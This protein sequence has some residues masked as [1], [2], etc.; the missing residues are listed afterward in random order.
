MAN[1]TIDITEGTGTSLDAEELTVSSTTVKRERMQ[2][3][4]TTAAAIQAVTNA[5]PSATEY[6]SAVRLVGQVAHDAADIGSPVKIGG[7]AVY[8]ETTSPAA[9]DRVDAWFNTNGAMFVH[10]YPWLGSRMRVVSDGT[11]RGVSRTNVALTSVTTV[12]SLLGA[13]GSGLYNYVIGMMLTSSA[14]S[15]TVL[16][17]ETVTGT[18][19]RWKMHTV[20]YQPIVVF[21]P[22][23]LYLFASLS[24]ELLNIKS[25]ASTDIN[26]VIFS[27]ASDQAV[28]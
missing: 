8:N 2:V 5:D 22:M 1:S 9:G 25:S 26:G 7:K 3:T 10:S 11:I 19:T 14:A 4:G 21:A 24:N 20:Q 17:I 15:G 12:Q 6:G 27:V 13:A 18:Q 23:S 28:V 16:T